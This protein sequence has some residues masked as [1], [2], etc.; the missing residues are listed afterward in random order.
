MR[1]FR[2]VSVPMSGFQ[3]TLLIGFD[4]GVFSCIFAQFFSQDLPLLFSQEH[5]T[6]CRGH[7]A[8]SIMRGHICS[9]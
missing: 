3:R 5:I 1:L 8:L 2:V 4:C 9:V 7:I 6:Q